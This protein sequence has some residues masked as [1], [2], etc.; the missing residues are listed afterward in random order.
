MQ[1]P[2]VM[3]WPT[4][5]PLAAG[6]VAISAHTTDSARFAKG[7]P[8]YRE[9]QRYHRVV[10][11]GLHQALALQLEGANEVIIDEVAIDEPI[12]DEVA[13]QPM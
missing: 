1:W 5:D 6:P 12:V 3:P 11:Q 2:E 4:P 13:T 9:R 7:T 8:R 10:H